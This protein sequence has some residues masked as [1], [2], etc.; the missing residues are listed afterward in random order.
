MANLMTSERE[1]LSRTHC[2][3]HKEFDYLC[4]YCVVSALVNLDIKVER[5]QKEIE[6]LN[7]MITGQGSMG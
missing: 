1:V 2:P 3:N 5:Q 7:H 6:R 4:H